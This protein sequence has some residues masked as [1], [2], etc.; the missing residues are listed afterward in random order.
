MGR[1]VGGLVRFGRG[2]CGGCG[3]L[4]DGL[5]IQEKSTR[6]KE[7]EGEVDN[8][9]ESGWNAIKSKEGDIGSNS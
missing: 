4:C 1:E 8:I 5:L 9:A 6:E 3:G 2:G 7:K